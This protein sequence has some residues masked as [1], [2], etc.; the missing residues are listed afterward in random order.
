MPKSQ[1]RPELS[2]RQLEFY[3]ITRA[4]FQQH[5]HFPK[6]KIIMEAMG[7]KSPASVV[8]YLNELERKGYLERRG[9]R[10]IIFKEL[11]LPDEQHIPI[12]GILTDTGLIRSDDKLGTFN[13]NVLFPSNEDIYGYRVVS[14][15]LA[16][17]MFGVGDIIFLGRGDVQQNGLA[18]VILDAKLLLKRIWYE[19][20]GFYLLP[21][22]PHFKNPKIELGPSDLIVGPYYGHLTH[23]KFVFPHRIEP[24]LLLSGWQ[25]TSNGQAA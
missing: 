8:Q 10:N 7:L 12:A 25:Q 15:D 5:G 22:N 18:L 20:D 1:A 23:H 14:P 2:P 11:A 4:H 13:W 6:Y 19:P 16:T 9:R 17:T 3:T 24:H 21:H